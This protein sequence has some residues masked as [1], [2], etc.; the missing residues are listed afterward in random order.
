[1]GVPRYHFEL[2]WG[3]LAP[4]HTPPELVRAINAEINRVIAAPELRAVLEREGAEPAPMGADEFAA[5]IRRE[6]DGWKKVAKEADIRA[7]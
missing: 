5:T 2:W 1:M 4:P 7:E 6:I 3:V